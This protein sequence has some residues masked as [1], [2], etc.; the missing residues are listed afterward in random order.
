MRP[1][2]IGASLAHPL[3]RAG[4]LGAFVSGE[5]GEVRILSANHVV[6]AENA[7]RP[8][9]P[10]L[11]PGR[12]DG[13]RN[14][15]DVVGYLAAVAALDR[16]EL[17]SVDCA[18]VAPD[19]TVRFDTATLAGVGTLAGVDDALPDEDELV[20]K[21]GRTTGHTHGRITNFEMTPVRLDYPSG[22]Y[23]FDRLWEVEGTDRA[24]SRPGDSGALVFRSRDRAARGMIIGG[25]AA[26]AANGT[27]LSYVT[28]M[29]RIL[30]RLN[31]SLL[32]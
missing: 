4:T 1:V 31:V 22:V 2:G 24:F 28:A 11:Q 9:D 23:A 15:R 13:G 14:P 26:G 7:G 19:P 17:N 3:V 21:L 32:A 29:G 27:G 10:I 30:R 8:D 18:L 16:G 5:R 25:T 20:E 6:A 12:K